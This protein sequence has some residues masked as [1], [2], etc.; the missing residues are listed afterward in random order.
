MDTNLRSSRLTMAFH[1]E[2]FLN[3]QEHEIKF[4]D[5]SSVIVT[6]EDPSEL[7]AILRKPCSDIG[8]GV[9]RM[10][11]NGGKTDLIFF[12]SEGDDFEFPSPNGD[13]CEVRK[14]TTSRSFY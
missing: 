11:V 3:N 2:A 6:G 1:R 9:W 4:A 10:L 5:N 14:A 13:I 7:S 8:S 12:N